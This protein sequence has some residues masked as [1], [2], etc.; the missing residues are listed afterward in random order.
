MGP[1]SPVRVY[2]LPIED[3]TSPGQ[4]LRWFE[5]L[6]ADEREQAG[7]FLSEALRTP[8]VAAHALLRRC[9]SL[10]FP[11]APDIVGIDRNPFGKPMLARPALR[12]QLSFSLSH[13]CGL[14]ACA[15]SPGWDIGVDVEQVASGEVDALATRALAP[16]E[17]NEVTA[18]PA[19]QRQRRF[20][21]LWT[22]KE[23]YVKALGVGL[24]TP[25]GLF[26]VLPLLTPP[27]RPA[28]CP[29]AAGASRWQFAQATPTS[30]HVLSVAFRRPR[31]ALLP[32]CFQR[33][34]L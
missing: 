4:E 8:Y 9:L 33:A 19:P 16:D 18:V 1:A 23:A 5:L 29:S 11:E 20:A 26:S 27:L 17:Q 22:L 25:P 2:W 3:A 30:C 15:I 6:T 28:G 14:A 32:V 24:R 10:H 13:T 21:E 7:R 34:E 31:D 12:R